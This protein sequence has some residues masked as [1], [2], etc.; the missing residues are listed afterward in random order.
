MKTTVSPIK[1]IEEAQSVDFPADTSQLEFNNLDKKIDS[2]G[3]FIKSTV[4]CFSLY[5]LFEILM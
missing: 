1:Q 5:F 4:L 2:F 3:F